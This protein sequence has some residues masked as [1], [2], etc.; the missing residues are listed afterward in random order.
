MVL[1]TAQLLCTVFQLQGIEA[2]YRA[3][4][5]N[6]P[7]SIWARESKQNYWW[8]IQHGYEL[9]REYTRRYGKIHK[10]FAAIQWCYNNM[11]Q[12]EFPRNELTPFAIAISDDSKCR[13]DPAFNSLTTVGKYRLYYKQDKAHLHAW[14]QNKPS[15]I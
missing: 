2:P 14:K 5:K 7:C 3:T 13:K 8:L 11:D 4:H 10:S 9:A 12:L 6:H 15:W 1:E